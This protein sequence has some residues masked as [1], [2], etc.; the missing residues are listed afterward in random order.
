LTLLFQI[1]DLF[2]Q[3][4][5]PIIQFFLLCEPFLSLLLLSVQPLLMFAF[6]FIEFIVKFIDVSFMQSLHLL[7][8]QIEGLN[9]LIFVEDAAFQGSFL[10]NELFH[11][12]IPCLK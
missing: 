2:I 12:D 6:N 7:H 5:D 3:L 8:L 10:C 1:I 11:V 9:L 4:I